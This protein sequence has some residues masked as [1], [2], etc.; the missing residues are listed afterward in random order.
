MPRKISPEL[1]QEIYLRRDMGLEAFLGH[2]QK[3]FTENNFPDDA[4][5]DRSTVIRHRNKQK[6]QPPKELAEDRP[7]QWS[8]A[9][10]HL[11]AGERIILDGLALY[12][13]LGHQA[14]AG[15]FTGP[16]YPI[17]DEDPYQAK[18]DS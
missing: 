11:W 9:E 8:E 6:E 15:P 17:D 13:K 7:F 12:H 18:A 4:I 10:P 14:E 3:R 2:L 1:Q 5:P 16:K